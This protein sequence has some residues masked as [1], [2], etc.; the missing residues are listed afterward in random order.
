M[1]GDSGGTFMMRLFAALVAALLLLCTGNAF[2]QAAYVHA[3]TGTATATTG[4]AQRALKI[5]DTLESGSTIS[6]GE[7]SS[8]VLKFE[9][10]QVM[11]LAERTSF[12]IVDY[13]YNKER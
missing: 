2:A 8:A 12:R 11:A 3:M 1:D 4:T 6:T 13:R 7:K 5:G 10:G 9:D